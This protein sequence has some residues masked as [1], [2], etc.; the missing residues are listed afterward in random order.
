MNQP[1]CSCFPAVTCAFP[2]ALAPLRAE[3]VLIIGSGFATHNLGALR[4]GGA[5]GSPLTWAVEFEAW[6]IE[7]MERCQPAERARRLLQA[8]TLAPHFRLAH[9][10]EEHFI[11]IYVAL[12]AASPE[13]DAGALASRATPVPAEDDVVASGEVTTSVSRGAARRVI[14][15]DIVMGSA[16][17][18][19]WVLE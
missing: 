4:G 10:R 19:S 11:P 17:F 7:A 16:S 12:G 2:Q 5:G 3:G 8:E 18:A 15:H 6:L 1:V 14:Q 13:L 9:P